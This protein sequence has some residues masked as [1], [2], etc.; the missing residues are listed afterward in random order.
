MTVDFRLYLITDR[1]VSR[2]PL[3]EAVREALKGGVRAVQLREK[4]LPVRE[5][6]S[7][8]K[9]L[10]N[11]TREYGAKLF[12]NERVDVA[13]EVDADGVHVGYNGINIAS[14]RKIVGKNMLIGCSTHNKMEAVSAQSGGADFITYGPIYETPSKMKYGLPVG[15]DGLK[16][17][18]CDVRIPIFAIGGIKGGNMR[19]AFGYGA[20]GVAMISAILGSDDIESSSRKFTQAVKVLERIICESCCP[21]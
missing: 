5:L 4:D 9:E 13:V 3:P 15:I 11:I 20:S 16:S 7:L 1:H 14:A 2:K 12:I 6:L 10:R 21:R 8:A 18:S 17:L 19:Y